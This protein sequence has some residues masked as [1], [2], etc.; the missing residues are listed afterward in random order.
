MIMIAV[1]A[2]L[3]DISIQSI[4]GRNSNCIPLMHQLRA[5]TSIH[6]RVINALRI[7]GAA[8]VPA[9]GAAMVPARGPPVLGVGAGGTRV[10]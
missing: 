8:M 4:L 10:R 3:T 7:R 9:R 2:L 5:R 1:S 6:N